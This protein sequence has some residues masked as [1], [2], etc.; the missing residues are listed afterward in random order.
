MIEDGTADRDGRGS[1]FSVS[2]LAGVLAD[3]SPDAL[4]ALSLDGRVLFW[5]L[6]AES[7]FG[8][9]REEAVGRW[10]RDLIVPEDRIDETAQLK[11]EAMARDLGAELDGDL[12]SQIAGNSANP[13][14]ASAIARLISAPSA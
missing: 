4:V 7:I 11:A 13:L 1:E 5:N 6:A 2:R 9:G 12:R 3:A 14:P 8:Y 10:A